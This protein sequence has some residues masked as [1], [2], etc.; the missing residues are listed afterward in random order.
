[1]EYLQKNEIVRDLI[2]RIAHSKTEK[3]QN[4]KLT[5]EADDK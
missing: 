1:M 2:R 4:H 3:T 5:S